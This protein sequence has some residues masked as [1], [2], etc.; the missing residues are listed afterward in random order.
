MLKIPQKKDRKIALVIIDAQEKF[1]VE[2]FEHAAESRALHA[3][4]IDRVAKMFRA[5]GRPVVFVH[6]D[7]YTHGMSE[8]DP[9]KERLFPEI[10]VARGDIH[11]HKYHMNSFKNTVLEDVV[12]AAG[13][14]SVL[15]AG[16]FTQ[17]CVMST[18]FGAPN[19]SAYLLEGGTIANEEKYNEAAYVVC[20]TFTMEDVEENL[21]AVKVVPR[22]NDQDGLRV[23]G[24]FGFEPKSAAPKA[25]SIPS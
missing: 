4:T 10:E 5:A 14:D 25:A 22:G 23:V 6:Y 17:Y 20:N 3:G 21:R 9:E 8:I 18:Y 13:C 11:V 7:G 1:F 2:P 19:L 24:L 16:A 15:L 12:R